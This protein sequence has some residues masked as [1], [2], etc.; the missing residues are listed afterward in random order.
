MSITLNLNSLFTET[1]TYNSEFDTGSVTELDT[2]SV[3]KLDTDFK[4]YTG[5]AITGNFIF[6]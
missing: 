5:E 6:S 1:V 3:T 2:R 4:F